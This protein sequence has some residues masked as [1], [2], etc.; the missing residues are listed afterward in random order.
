MVLI[1]HQISARNKT[2]KGQTAKC[3][4]TAVV[5]VRNDSACEPNI[6]ST[7]VLG[8]FQKLTTPVS[9]CFLKWRLARLF[10]IAPVSMGSELF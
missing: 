10:K 9:R 1:E 6:T 8:Q 7:R 4:R 3:A 2:E 5:A